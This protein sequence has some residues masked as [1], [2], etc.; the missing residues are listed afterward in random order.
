MAT[1]E[2]LQIVR[3][4]AFPIEIEIADPDGDPVDLSGAIVTV[5]LSRRNELESR[6]VPLLVLTSAAGRLTIVF[7]G[8]KSK[9]LGRITSAE[10]AAL[11][12]GYLYFWVLSTLNSELTTW[13]NE[14]VRIV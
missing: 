7:D 5:A 9:I 11:K 8:T 3:G 4:D 6:Q 13:A 14:P 10:T 2:S 12:A 1:N